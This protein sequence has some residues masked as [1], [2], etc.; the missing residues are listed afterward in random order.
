[1]EQ[2]PARQLLGVAQYIVLNSIQ[3]DATGI[4]LECP[5]PTLEYWLGA[6]EDLCTNNSN[7]TDGQLCCDNGCSYECMSPVEDPCAVSVTTNDDIVITWSLRV[8]RPP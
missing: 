2:K 6:C 8:Y 1:M 4:D 3:Y 7:C 5:G